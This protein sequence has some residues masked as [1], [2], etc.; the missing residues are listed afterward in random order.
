MESIVHE[1][2]IKES[3]TNEY[4]LD[5]FNYRIFNYLSLCCV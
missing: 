2:F 5:L 1:L 3:H 4:I